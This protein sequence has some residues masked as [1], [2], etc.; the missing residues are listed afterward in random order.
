MSTIKEE[1]RKTPDQLEREIDMRRENI[2][3][4]LNELGERLS[5]RR[6]VDQTVGYVR[7]NADSISRNVS[8]T[9]SRNAGP[10]TLAA[11]GL[12]AAGLWWMW[13]NSERHG[14]LDESH[15]FYGEYDFDVFD[16]Y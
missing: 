8:H 12:A 14:T 4:K 5:P 7:D 1:A 10:A 15:D 2:V 9:I 13:R 3:E 16:E 6:M 11:A